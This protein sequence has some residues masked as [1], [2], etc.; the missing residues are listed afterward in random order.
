MPSLF[1]TILSGVIALIAGTNA[2]A[3]VAKE[4]PPIKIIALGDSITKG[5]RSGVKPE[6]TFA[7][8]LQE[9]LKKEGINAD[10]VNVGIGGENTAQA[11]RRLKD[12]VIDKKPAFVTI[13]YGANDSYVDKGKTAPRL[14]VNEYR[15]NLTKIVDDLRKAGI[16]PILMTTNRLGDK[17][18]N[19]G[20]GEHPGKRLE[21]YVK[22]CRDVANVSKVP[23]VD[24]YEFWTKM[25]TEGMDI[26]RWM[27][28]SCHPNVRGHQEM[29][30]RMLPVILQAIRGK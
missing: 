16:K 21:A 10:V 7:S 26:D 27:T 14:T 6:E 22:I 9:S 1:P 2:I 15:A 23:L 20:A 12:Q 8:R 3:Q 29:A 17:H 28:D 5:V 30:T 25:N 24:H 11:L 19:N 13:M 18:L 4:V